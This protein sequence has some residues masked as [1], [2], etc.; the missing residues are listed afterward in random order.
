MLPVYHTTTPAGATLPPAA[1]WT[2]RGHLRIPPLRTGSPT[3]TSVESFDKAVLAALAVR[4]DR[5]SGRA[6]QGSRA[7]L[8]LT[9]TQS[10]GR[11]CTAN[12]AGRSPQTRP[13][14]TRSLSSCILLPTP[15]SACPPCA[16]YAGW[17]WLGPQIA[18][19]VENA[20]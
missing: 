9:N 13:R 11:A 4:L 19:L 3:Y 12:T 6:G 15:P 20:H 2:L 5:T 8:G 14:C 18:R 10:R 16:W 17:L 7:G 1:P